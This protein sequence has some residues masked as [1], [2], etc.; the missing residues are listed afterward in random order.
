MPISSRSIPL[1]TSDAVVFDEPL[2]VRDEGVADG[3]HQRRR[4]ERVPPMKPEE[5]IGR[6]H[7]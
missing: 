6:A 3:L 4:G 2:D 1:A 5:Q 7:V